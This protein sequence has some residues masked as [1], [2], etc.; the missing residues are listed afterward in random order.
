MICTCRVRMDYM[1]M[2]ATPFLECGR[3]RE[4]ELHVHVAGVHV[5]ATLSLV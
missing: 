4:L 1:H 5:L 2:L 3:A